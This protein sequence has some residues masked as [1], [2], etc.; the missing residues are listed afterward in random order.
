MVP[1]FLRWM[2]ILEAPFSEQ[3]GSRI[4]Q[5][6]PMK[7]DLRAFC[8]VE[9]LAGRD[10]AV[11]VLHTQLRLRVETQEDLHFQ[12]DDVVHQDSVDEEEDS[13]APC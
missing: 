9:A 4:F 12:Q 11:A 7:N 13:G 8:S 2:L 6:I 3:P 10:P 1:A 5:K